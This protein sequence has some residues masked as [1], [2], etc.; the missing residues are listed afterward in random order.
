MSRS[1]ETAVALE[2]FYRLPYG[3]RRLIVRA[4]RPHY[5]ASSQKMRQKRGEY[6]YKPFDEYRCIFVHIPKT[7]GVSVSRA[8]FGN[9]AGGHA[10]IC[11]YQ[12]V[13]SRR[14]FDSYF[15]FSF[16][17]NPWDRLHSAYNFLRS[18][19]MN[20]RDLEWSSRVLSRFGSFDEFVRQWITRETVYSYY[21]FVPQTDFLCLPG[22]DQI[23]VDFVGR[24]ERIELDFATVCSHIGRSVE[25]PHHNATKAGL[26][27]Y[28][29][30]YTSASRRI[31]AAVY[32]R[33]IEMFGYEF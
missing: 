27:P 14:E 24:F 12:A 18:G 29:N 15:K 8:L 7:G 17:R 28:R 25:L 26:A 10:T 32:R 20:E 5:F 3:L 4:F 31:V 21:H 11:H 9:L 13:F 30:A 33:D 1:N 19:G 6:T 16:V 22:Q 2:T 23:A